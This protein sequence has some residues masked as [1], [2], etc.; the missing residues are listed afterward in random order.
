MSTVIEV[1]ETFKE[2]IMKILKVLR[3]AAFTVPLTFLLIPCQ[4]QSVHTLQDSS[5]IGQKNILKLNVPA[6]FIKNFSL[7]Y[8]RAISEK[9]A[10]AL[11]LRYMPESGLPIKSTIKALIDNTDTWRNARNLRT[12]NFSI[13][14]EYRFYLGKRV[15]Q[16]F[17]LAPFAKYTHYTAE[18]PFQFDVK[19]PVTGETINEMIPLQGSVNTYTA[20]LLIGAQW[21]LSRV[22]SLDWWILGPNYGASKG[23]VTG[24]RSL[25]EYE[26]QYLRDKLERL[27]VPLTKKK[28]IV[29]ENGTQIDFN[30]GWA[31]VRAGLS[32]G[33]RF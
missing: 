23:Q 29:D 31:G 24:N 10:L 16:G 30:G 8:E 26:Q 11:G 5:G 14:P 15:F 32:L 3:N 7:Q 2:Q 6:L 33:I 13:T 12:S 9:N 25:N 21:K 17:Y 1:P 18:L 22:L 28:Y 19:H 27:K 4:A 20:G